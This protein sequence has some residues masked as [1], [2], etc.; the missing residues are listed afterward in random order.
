MLNRN[1]SLA[2]LVCVAASVAAFGQAN[3]GQE[4]LFQFFSQPSSSTLFSG[5]SDTGNLA[6]PLISTNGPTGVAAILPT[7]A[8]SFYLVGTNG[9]NSLQAADSTFSNFTTIN[10]LGG[11]PTAAAVTPDGKYLLVAAPDPTNATVETFYIIDATTNAI[12]TPGGL[13]MDGLA[14]FNPSDVQGTC[15]ACW[16]AV[17]GD[18]QFAF[19]LTN[20]P[21]GSNV[22]QYNLVTRTRVGTLS[23]GGEATSVSMSPLGRLYVTAESQIYVIDP[24]TFL[25]NAGQNIPISF[26]PSILRYTPD[27]TTAYTVNRLAKTGGGWSMAQINLTTGTVITWPPPSPTPPNQFD[28]IFVASNNRIFTFSSA[29]NQLLDV[30]PSP[31]AAQA[32]TSIPNTQVATTIVQN[33]TLAVA[34]SNELPQANWLFLLYA[35]GSQTDLLRVNLTT[36]SADSNTLSTFNSGVFET[37]FVPA[38][39]GATSFLQFNNSQ[40]VPNGGT[41][42]PLLATVLNASGIPVFNQPVTFT[43]DASNSLVINNPTPTTNA[44]GSVST[45]VSVPAAGATCPQGVCTITVAAGAATTT[46]TVTVPTSSTGGGG[47]GTPSSQVQIFSGDGQLL[48]AGT[49]QGGNGSVA[50]PLVVQV[51]DTNGKPLPNIPVTFSVSAG[52]GATPNT[53]QFIGAIENSS[54]IPTDSNGLAGV[55]FISEG[56]PQGS[57][58]QTTIV[59]ASTSL[60]SVNF[61]IVEFV[62]DFGGSGIPQVLLLSP[63]VGIPLQV[64]A[65]TPLVGGIQAQILSTSQVATGQPIPGVG[66]LIVDPDNPG[67]DADGVQPVVGCQGSSNSNAQGI[68]SCNVV[69]K[70]CQTESHGVKIYVGN[71]YEFDRTIQVNPGGAATITIASGNNQTGQS[72]SVAAAPLVAQVVDA[73]GNPVAGQQVNWTH[74]GSVTLSQTN[75][76]TSPSGQVSTSVTFGPTA[77]PITVTAT[78]LSGGSVTFKLTDVVSVA[79]I[80]LVSGSPQTATTGQQFAQ[81]LVFVVTD[82]GGN[83]LS[84]VQ[85]N[86]SVQ[87]GSASVTPV[88]IAT[89]SAGHA[90]T[91]VTAGTNSAGPI[92]IAATANGFVA[93]ASL[94]STPPG[95][96]ITASS[97]QNAASF[98]PG[99]T[100]CGLGLVTGNGLAPGV[101]GVIP[102]NSFGPLGFSLGP[103]NSM[104]INL[105]QVP[106]SSVSN[107]NGVQQVN[108]QTPCEV[109]PGPATVVIT[110]SG[111]ATTIQGVPVLASQP[112]IF[113]FPGPNGIQYGAVLRAAD[114]NYV[115]PSSFANRGELYYVVV[116]GLG[117]TSP[118]ATTDNPGNGQTVLAQVIAGVNDAG[119]GT[120]PATYAKGLLGVYLVP[121]Q[122]P[123]TAPT[124]ANQKLS[125]GTFTGQTVTYSNSVFI[126]GVK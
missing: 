106:I 107:Q 80:K 74:T 4:Y 59:T 1:F 57:G 81:P 20:R 34:L 61:T 77:G 9:T 37:T 45:T 79:A 56:L 41:S 97:F 72:G 15:I 6:A 108:F 102:G 66:I 38:Q 125:V 2:V 32:V 29:L 98:A 28:D 103:V 100:P 121:F 89:D 83:P 35:N 86:F 122:I 12:L 94:T 8:G 43:T 5:Y 54:A 53:A 84:G 111:V 123:L 109:L 48:Q 91:V 101:S 25:L 87:S 104:T 70:T 3:Q 27:G 69:A 67:N 49:G 71:L 93:T 120:G 68:A 33:E 58:Y 114:F 82:K 92:V 52:P 117:Q 60:G 55:I 19:V 126:P 99:L 124:G 30:I 75:L 14:N 46:F 95:P 39:S 40:N 65:G 62:S 76:I 18:S 63:T 26:E 113:T 119:V 10:G 88:G 11:P 13:Q 44:N 23:T 17:S 96:S 24:A 73:C 118:L 42:R 16:I 21:F 115:T 78:L 112:G 51:T 90:Q 105:V 22:T 64:T 31:F 110:I 50:D 36:N 116:T 7:P 85:V 47:G